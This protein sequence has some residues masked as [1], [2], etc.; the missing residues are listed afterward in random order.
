MLASLICMI[1][2]VCFWAGGHPP[3][4]FGVLVSVV[5]FYWAMTDSVARDVELGTRARPW[6]AGDKLITCGV[7]MLFETV[8]VWI[9]G[10]PRPWLGLVAGLACMIVGANIEQNREARRG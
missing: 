1:V 10:M 3:R 4:S 5:L 6:H 7:L 8:A 9:E 2:T